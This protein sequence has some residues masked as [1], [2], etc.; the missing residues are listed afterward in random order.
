MAPFR[1]PRAAA[2]MSWPGRLLLIVGVLAAL[3][4]GR[5]LFAPLALALLLIR[6]RRAPLSRTNAW[7]LGQSAWRV[8]SASGP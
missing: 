2:E 6:T 3:Y 7:K 4:F 8:I 1:R 5:E